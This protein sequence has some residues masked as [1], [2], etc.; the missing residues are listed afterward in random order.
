M[1]TCVQNSIIAP[2]KINY[3]H[4][5]SECYHFAELSLS[6][7]RLKRS[8]HHAG[9]N[10]DGFLRIEWNPVGSPVQI[11]QPSHLSRCENIRIFPLLDLCN[12]FLTNIKRF[13]FSRGWSTISIIDF[14]GIKLILYLAEDFRVV[15]NCLSNQQHNQSTDSNRR[16]F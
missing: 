9:S 12:H 11:P 2:L 4:N 13:F 10:N 3:F 16:S 6:Q 1:M 5:W 8:T 15:V 14:R 7:F